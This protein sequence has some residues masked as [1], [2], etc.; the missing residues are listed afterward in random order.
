MN[1][2]GGWSAGGEATGGQDGLRFAEVARRLAG[3]AGWLIG[4]DP[5]TFWRATPGEL[6]TIFRTMTGADAAADSEFADAALLE[7]LKEMFPDG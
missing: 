7:R 2:A 4:W 5:D 1:A 3:L 6:A